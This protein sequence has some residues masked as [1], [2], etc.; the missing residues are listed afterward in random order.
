MATINIVLDGF[1]PASFCGH[2]SRTLPAK[3]RCEMDLVLTNAT[4]KKMP[5]QD[6]PP[7]LVSYKWLERAGVFSNRMDC[8]RRRKEGFPAPLQLSENKIAWR[9]AEVQEWLASRPRRTPKSGSQ[10]ATK[11]EAAVA[12]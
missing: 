12:P 3:S 1:L 11:P 8:H 4:G 5:G 2:C 10:K 6:D 9:W 7:L